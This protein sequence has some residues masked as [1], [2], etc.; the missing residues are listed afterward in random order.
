MLRSSGGFTYIAVLVLVVIMG[1]VIGAA[2][3]SWT[4]L[5]KREREQELLFRGVQI[6]KAI[7]EW[8]SPST[9]PGRVAPPARPLNDLKD[10]V[11]DPN[12]LT[13]KHYLRRD[14]DTAYDDPITGK[15]WE[16]IKVAGRGIVGV[17][18]T[19]EDEPVKQAGFLEMFYPLDPAK[20]AYLITMF[21]NF[22][23]KKKYSE[24]QFAWS[25]QTTG[26]AS[27]PG[28]R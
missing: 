5:M 8:H 24:W 10:L 21:K 1:I 9:A 22:E 26:P 12:S 27:L 18:S 7:K 14:P 13:K 15:K 11:T 17:K 25:P 4:M 3:Q 19:S 20:D 16:T 28:Q 6:V 23:G 2:A